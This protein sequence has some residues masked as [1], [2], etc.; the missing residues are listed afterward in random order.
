MNIRT[1]IAAHI[2]PIR[3]PQVYAHDTNMQVYVICPSCKD[4]AIGIDGRISLHEIS[5]TI[6][7][8]SEQRYVVWH[9]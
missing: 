9:S 1:W 4:W 6:C 5:G 8:G 2:S 7:P 3:V